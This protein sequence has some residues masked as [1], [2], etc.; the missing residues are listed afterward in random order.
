MRYG[1]HDTADA[2]ER[3]DDMVNILRDLSIYREARDQIIGLQYDVNLMH[4]RLALQLG[5]ATKRQLKWVR[6]LERGVNC[7]DAVLRPLG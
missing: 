5:P 6:K 2:I 4:D 1:Q 7:L 3:L